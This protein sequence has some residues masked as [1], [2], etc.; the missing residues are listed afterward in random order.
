M[1]SEV[2]GDVVT[3]VGTT[4]VSGRSS[5]ETDLVLFLVLT[6]LTLSTVIIETTSLIATCCAWVAVQGS[7][8]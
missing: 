8:L 3:A 5:L 2:I 6:A 1:S 7:G 4:S